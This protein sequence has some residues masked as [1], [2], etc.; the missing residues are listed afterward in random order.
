MPIEQIKTLAITS[1]QESISSANQ[2]E[3]THAVENGQV[4]FFP[5]LSF[6]LSPEEQTVLT[7]DYVNP[8][9]KNISYHPKTCEIRGLISHIPHEQ[10]MLLNTLLMRFAGQ[11]HQFIHHLFPQYTNAIIIGRTSFRPVEISGRTSSYRKDDTRLHVDAF[12]ANPNHGL[13]ILR[14]FCNINPKNQA[15]V[16]R[17]G[18]PFEE[19][20][21]QFLPRLKKTLPGSAALLHLLKITKRRRK[22]YDHYMLQLHDNMKA[23][24]TY[25]KTARQ[26]EVHFPAASTWVAQTDHVSHAAMSGQHLL[27]QTFYLPVKAMLDESKSPLR[28]LEKLIQKALV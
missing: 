19:V 18:E 16:W 6:E 28:V 26:Q 9:S 7:P 12:P 4:L 15:R 10:H 17:L 14:V 5:Q 20:A 25:Q 2:T 13:R 23:D 27:E 3:Y 22:L 24:E 8:K 1:W 21:Q 11:A